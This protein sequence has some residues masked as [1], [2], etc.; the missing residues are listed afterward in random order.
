MAQIKRAKSQPY[1][2]LKVSVIFVQLAY[3]NVLVYGGGG[4][5]SKKWGLNHGDAEKD[6][7]GALSTSQRI[8]GEQQ[9]QV[10]GQCRNGIPQTGVFCSRPGVFAEVVFCW[11]HCNIPLGGTAGGKLVGGWEVE[12]GE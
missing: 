1:L 7:D 10:C 12:Y 8:C 2:R 6:D 3:Y 4:G 11:I 9:G 5:G